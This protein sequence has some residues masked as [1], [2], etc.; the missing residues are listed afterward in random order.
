MDDTINY[1][2]DK[3]VSLFN[4]EFNTDLNIN[5]FSEWDLAKFATKDIYK[6]YGQ[7]NF[8]LDLVP[9]TEAIE[10]VK[11]LILEGQEFVIVTSVKTQEGI[12]DKNTWLD[13]FLPEITERHFT[14]DKSSIQGDLIIDDG[15]HNLTS[16]SAINK[17]LFTRPWNM[18]ETRFNRASTW[19]EIK[20]II[21]SMEV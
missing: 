19:S 16:T 20:S 10:V 4:T 12:N 9:I 11:S 14:T 13:K 3:V 18:S 17:L 6:Y 2:V 7:N 5:I 15:V 21:K 1:S 8:F